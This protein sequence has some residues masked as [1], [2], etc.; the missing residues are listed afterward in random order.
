M[1][2]NNLFK[3]LLT[4]Q[5]VALLAYTF[6]AYQREG[7]DLFSVFISNIQSL[8]WSG[9]FNLDFLC[10]LTLSGLWIMWRN[11]FSGSSILFGIIA[12]ILGIVVFAPFLLWLLYKENADL[13]RVF[14]GDR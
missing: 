2:N 7:A 1:S 9:Q 13:K 14:I 6:I 8:T 10:Y 12:A 5:T 4:V 11:K 3:I